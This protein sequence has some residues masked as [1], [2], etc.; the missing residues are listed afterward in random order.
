MPASTE[1]ILWHNSQFDPMI[2]PCLIW[3]CNAGLEGW[4]GAASV[5]RGVSGVPPG[6]GGLE[7]NHKEKS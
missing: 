3:A 1:I 5:L 6:L 4:E 7:E 2:L